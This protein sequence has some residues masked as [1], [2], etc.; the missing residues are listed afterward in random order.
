MYNAP[1]ARVHQLRARIRAAA[2]AGAGRVRARLQMLAWR[3]IAAADTR[4]LPVRT[5]DT[6]QT[7]GEDQD[8]G[9]P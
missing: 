2:G 9:R 8:G 5:P 3:Q 1:S 7:T 4:P 6:D